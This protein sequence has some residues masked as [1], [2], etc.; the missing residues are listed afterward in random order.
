MLNKPKPVY[1]DNFTNDLF[2]SDNKLFQIMSSFK[3]NSP[4]L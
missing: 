3:K 4:Y 2:I 1:V